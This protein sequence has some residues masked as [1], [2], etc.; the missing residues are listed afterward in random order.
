MLVTWKICSVEHLHHQPCSMNWTWQSCTL[1]C[2]LSLFHGLL[3]EFC[4]PSF[5]ANVMRP[6]AVLF[7][8]PVVP[9]IVLVICVSE[10]ASGGAARRVIRRMG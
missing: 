3:C 5:T 9:S 2:S 10:K 7:N 4:L 1:M 6:V 8:S